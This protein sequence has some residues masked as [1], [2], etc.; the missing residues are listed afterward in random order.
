MDDMVGSIDARA[1]EFKFD[2]VRIYS[3]L[4]LAAIWE[5]DSLARSHTNLDLFPPPPFFV[6]FPRFLCVSPFS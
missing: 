3:L 2:P 6:S 1:L 5:D 4:D